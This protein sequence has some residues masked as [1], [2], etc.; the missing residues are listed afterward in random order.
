MACNKI[1]WILGTPAQG[2]YIGTCTVTLS[3]GSVAIGSEML[4]CAQHDSAGNHTNARS[5]L[6]ICIVGPNGGPDD[7]V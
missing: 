3:E 7:C 1:I 6:Y 4:R 5:N 2:R